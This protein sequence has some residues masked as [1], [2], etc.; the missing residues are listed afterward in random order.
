MA[1]G[2]KGRDG[3]ADAGTAGDR[4]R[5]GLIRSARCPDEGCASRLA[6]EERL[7]RRSA[8]TNWRGPLT[9]GLSSLGRPELAT[10][11]LAVFRGLL[12]DHDASGDASRTTDAFD[13]FLVPWS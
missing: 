8:P 9:R 7:D 6:A 5:P 2:Q 3:P 1:F 13:D 10:L 12:M 4:T 11:L